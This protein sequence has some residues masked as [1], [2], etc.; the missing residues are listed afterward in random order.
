M[1][2]RLLAIAPF[3]V[4]VPAQQFVAELDPSPATTVASNAHNAIAGG[5]YAWFAADAAGAG[6]ELHR[7]DGTA[8]GTAV[9][10][11]LGPGAAGSS[12]RPLAVVGNYVVFKASNPHANEYAVWVSDGTTAGTVRLWGPIDSPTEVRVLGTVNGRIVCADNRFFWRVF[13]SDL[14]APGTFQIGSFNEVGEAVV[15]GNELL[16]LGRGSDHRLYATTGVGLVERKAL[17]GLASSGFA[18]LGAHQFF[19][20]DVA[21]QTQLWR[22]DGTTAGTTMVLALGPTQGP[23]SVAT[24]GGRLLIGAANQLFA[25]DGTAAGTAAIAAPVTNPH[26]LTVVGNL[27]YFRSGGAATGEELWRTDG[28]A[29]GTLLVSG[30]A[31]A[32]YEHMVPVSGRLFCFVTTTNPPLLLS[33]NGTAAGTQTIPVALSPAYTSLAALGTEAVGTFG[34]GSSDPEVHATD[35]TLA[36]TRR[37]THEQSRP[38]VRSAGPGAALGDVLFVVADTAPFGSELWRTDGTAAGTSLVQDLAPGPAHGVNEV[39]TF[40]GQLWFTSGPALWRSDGTPVGSSLVL[41]PDPAALWLFGVVA[42]PDHLLFSTSVNGVQRL[43]R[44]DGSTAGTVELDSVGNYQVLFNWLQVGGLTFYNKLDFF[45]RELWC[46][47]GTPAGRVN[48]GL[49]D[50]AFGVLGSRVLFSRPSGAAFEVWSTTGTAASNVLV[51][52]VAWPPTSSAAI[53]DRLVWVASSGHVYATDGIAQNAALPVPRVVHR[54]VRGSDAVYL[55]TEE[56]VEGRVVYRTDGTSAGTMRA[57]RVGQGPGAGVFAFEALGAG[58]RLFL[59]ASD[60]SSGSEPWIGDG[61]SSGTQLLADLH[62]N[63]NSN[64]QLLGVAGTRAFWI[65]DDGIVGRELWKVDLGAVGAANVQSI[66]AGCVGAGGVPRLSADGLP[67]PGTG[68]LA[69]TMDRA[70][71]SSLALWFTGVGAGSLPLGGGC[72][73]YPANVLLVSWSLTDAFGRAAMPLP[74]PANPALIGVML[75][76]QGSAI[77]ALGASAFGT[78]VTQGLL[79]VIGG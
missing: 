44:S 60:G 13:S 72:E 48:L 74:L 49:A 40:Q 55:V 66:G 47:D 54:P 56:P 9:W 73:F 11:D 6:I 75:T 58:N 17:G 18:A 26:S 76:V 37:L 50:R 8:A 45:Q 4:A 20:V 3:A 14:T 59:A 12:P 64:P 79:L 77:D 68:T 29:A 42:A 23:G 22:T 35:G 16:L 34:F 61:T 24:V 41:Q 1:L 46:T 5:G 53:G 51:A 2:L 63:G 21:S 52:Q 7:T 10:L 39:V 78:S 57:T 25:S 33:S 15:H 62:P 67:L 65:A 30:L 28:T 69:L 43:W 32:R 70:A 19:L 31:N 36:G 71:P 27:A 38:G